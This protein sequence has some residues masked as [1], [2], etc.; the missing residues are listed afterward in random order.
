MDTEGNRLVWLSSEFICDICGFAVAVVAGTC[1]NRRSGK[2]KKMGERGIGRLAAVL[3]ILSACALGGCGEGTRQAPVA[4]RSFNSKMSFHVWIVREEGGGMEDLGKTPAE[5]PIE[6]PACWAWGV[7]PKGKADM[8]A[9]VQEIAAQNIPGLRIYDAK[10]DDL[11]H[12]EDLKG[13]QCL[14]IHCSFDV[15]DAGLAHLKELKG[16]RTLVLYGTKVTDA[17]LVHLKALKGLHSLNLAYNKVTDAGL[18]HLME[19]QGLR[20]LVLHGTKVTDSGLEHLK[21][22]K[23]LHS[24]NLAYNKVTD[25]GLVHLKEL[26]G[27][28][29]LNLNGTQVTDAG[30]AQ[31]KGL[32]GL[33][34][35]NLA[36]TKVTD[37]GL[38]HLKE[39]KGLQRLDLSD[40]QVTAAGV[41]EFKR[42][43][44]NVHVEY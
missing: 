36:W 40:T 22:L 37:A 8:Q 27:L 20:S 12:L 44:P 9:V 18:V 30:L 25:A 16:L 32:K 24:L 1:D 5:E 6:I 38:V 34:S 11:A 23:G 26:K 29:T 35:L 28:Q 2:E 14:D 4:A 19:L 31:L 33:Q 41:E 43:M 42:A 7:M 3:L 17:G 39:L 13:L 10:D 21:E 15:S